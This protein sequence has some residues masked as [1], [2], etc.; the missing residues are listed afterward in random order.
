MLVLKLDET[1]CILVTDSIISLF[2]KKVNLNNLNVV[3]LNS[4]K[5]I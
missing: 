3:F 4:L 1:K 2:Q 5:G